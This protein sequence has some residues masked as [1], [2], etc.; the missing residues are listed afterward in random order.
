VELEQTQ[1]QLEATNFQTFTVGKLDIQKGKADMVIDIS[2]HAFKRAKERCGLPKRA[3]ARTALRAF[4]LGQVTR[5]Q[6]WIL[7]NS[8]SITSSRLIL[9][10][11]NFNY[12]YELSTKNPKL[13]TI[14]VQKN[15]KKP[16]FKIYNKTT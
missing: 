1:R 16:H 13:V 2:Q 3:V 15:E 4:E 9:S 11:G 14:I 6:Q 8:L 5:D 7:S 10:Y 12:V